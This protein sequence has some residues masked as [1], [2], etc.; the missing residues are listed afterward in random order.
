MQSINQ[1]GK[2]P[3]GGLT[4][5]FKARTQRP[6]LALE[7]YEHYRSLAESTRDVDRVTRENYWQHA[8]HFLRTLSEHGASLE[9][10]T[11]A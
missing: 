6:E 3:R 2:R 10:K 1:S 7:R 5:S 9:P 11:P 8:E 4:R